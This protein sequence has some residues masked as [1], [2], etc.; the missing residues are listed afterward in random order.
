MLQY[1]D[2]RGTLDEADRRGIHHYR[3]ELA[4]WLDAQDDADATE[5]GDD[6]QGEHQQVHDTNQLPHNPMVPTCDRCRRHE[7]IQVA[8]H[9]GQSIL[10]DCDRGASRSGMARAVSVDRGVGSNLDA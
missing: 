7:F 9:A 5:H 6:G 4:D 8:I 3:E 10:R 2:A 1:R